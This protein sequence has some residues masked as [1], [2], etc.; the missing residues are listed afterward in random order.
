MPDIKIETCLKNGKEI[1]AWIHNIENLTYEELVVE[2]EDVVNNHDFSIVEVASFPSIDPENAFGHIFGERNDPKLWLFHT[3]ATAIDNMESSD[4]EKAMA[5]FF[6]FAQENFLLPAKFDAHDLCM[7]F[8]DH[9]HGSY[10]EKGD[11]AE[12]HVEG[13]YGFLPYYIK[14]HI[15]YESMVETLEDDHD[16]EFVYDAECGKFHA[17]SM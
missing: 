17:F 4:R 10:D 8:G 1:E 15:N 3:V 9:Y 6:E 16:M 14:N 2:I 12:E 11:Y 5:C 13:N 7:L